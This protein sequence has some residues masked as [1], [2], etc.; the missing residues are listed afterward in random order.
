VVTP[1]DPVQVTVIYD[2]LAP[3]PDR[4]IPVTE[5]WAFK[6][7]TKELTTISRPEELKEQGGY[8]STYTFAMSKEAPAGEYQAITTVSNGAMA[9]TVATQFRVQH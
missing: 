9:T 7:N 6:H 3:Q 4:Q 5:T 8:A 1:G 2:V